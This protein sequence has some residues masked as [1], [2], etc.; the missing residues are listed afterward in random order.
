M[1]EPQPDDT[2]RY[3]RASKALLVLSPFGAALAYGIAALQGAETRSCLIIAG[4]MFA[5]CLGASL[6][7]GLRGSKANSDLVWINLILRLLSRP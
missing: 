1:T 4:T 2:L 7:Y 6:L 5:M 3:K